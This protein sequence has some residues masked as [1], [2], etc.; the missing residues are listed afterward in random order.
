M[1]EAYFW[2]RYEVLV[3]TGHKFRLINKTYYICIPSDIIEHLREKYGDVD[4]L[5][6][7][8]ELVR[9]GSTKEEMIVIRIRRD[10]V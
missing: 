7:S 1:S 4:G 6:G 5:R 3:N 10:R 2:G 8:V 9:D